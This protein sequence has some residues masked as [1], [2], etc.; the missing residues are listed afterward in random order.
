M[1]DK[2]DIIESACGSRL[3]GFVFLMVIFPTLIIPMLQY[4]YGSKFL[5]FEIP[6][7][8]NS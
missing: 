2:D 8:R 3:R 7:V 1:A 6:K 5:K 4:S